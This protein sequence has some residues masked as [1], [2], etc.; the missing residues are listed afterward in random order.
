MRQKIGKK[1]EPTKM[2]S[3]INDK[4]NA[5]WDERKLHTLKHNSNANPWSYSKG[6]FISKPPLMKF[7]PG[8]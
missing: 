7:A 8:R 1:M 5:I 2:L 6:R 3:L 4:A